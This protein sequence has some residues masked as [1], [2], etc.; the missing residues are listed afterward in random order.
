MLVLIKI[1]MSGINVTFPKL[2]FCEESLMLLWNSGCFVFISFPVPCGRKPPLSHW[3][4][5]NTEE[6]V[7]LH[8]PQCSS[9]SCT[10]QHGRRWLHGLFK[11]TQELRESCF[12]GS[13]T[14][15][16]RQLAYLIEKE[17]W[18]GTFLPLWEVLP[19]ALLLADWARDEEATHN[20]ESEWWKPACSAGPSLWGGVPEVSAPS[21]SAVSRQGGA[22]F[23]AALQVPQS[24]M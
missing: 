1:L 12:Q 17:C 23:Q 18:E 3:P 14:D 5:R 15:C 21:R 7:E 4:E 20:R 6:A 10:A 19:A 16:D 8:S 22:E 9:S 13:V 24:L 2:I 11:L